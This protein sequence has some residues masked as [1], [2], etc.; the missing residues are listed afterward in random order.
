VRRGK[1]EKRRRKEREKEKKKLFVLLR[2]L[3]DDV[4]RFRRFQILL[5]RS[6]NSFL[7]LP[8]FGEKE[9]KRALCRFFEVSGALLLL[10]LFFFKKTTRRDARVG[11]RGTT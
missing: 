7:T 11:L 6:R 1:K 9:N 5:Y 3:D 10:S 2:T 4:F 8:F